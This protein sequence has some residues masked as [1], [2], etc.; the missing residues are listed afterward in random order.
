MI[1]YSIRGGIFPPFIQY[2]I[3]LAIICSAT[4]ASAQPFG[5]SRD[6][7]WQRVGSRELAFSLEAPEGWRFHEVDARGARL[8]PSDDDGPVM[9]VVAW[10]AL[11][12]PATPESAVVEHEGVLSRVVNYRRDAVE[13]I[14]TDDGEAA[15]VVTGRVRWRGGT[16]GV[17]FCAYAAEATHYVLG[18]FAPEATLAQFREDVFDRMMRSFRPHPE[19]DG[20]RDAPARP[21]AVP[22]PVEPTEPG[23][24]VTPDAPDDPDAPEDP[25]L[26]D[27]SEPGIGDAPPT[28]EV[29]RRLEPVG[30]EVD[31]P[32]APWVEHLNPAGFAVSIPIDWEVEVAEG[33]I[34]LTPALEGATAGA[35]LIWP[36]TGPDPGAEAA[37]RMALTPMPE[38]RITRVTSIEDAAAATLIQA[39]AD[40]G[41]RLMA[42]WAHDG[43]HGLLQM[44]AVPAEQWDEALPDLA[45]MIAS[46]RPGEWPVARAAEADFSGE[47]GLLRWRL[48][49]GWQIEGG[50]REDGGE[51]GIDVSA[52]GPGDDALRIRWRQPMQPRFRALTPLLESL[53]WREQ[54][55]YSSPE[56]GE[57]LTIYRRRG[58]EKFV[59][60]MLLARDLDQLR[61]TAI[62]AGPADGR[63][64]D[65][66]PQGGAEGH[67]ITAGGGSPAGPRERLYLAATAPAA[68]PLSTTCWEAAYLLADA[69]E[70]GLAEAVA[71][72]VTMV[73]SARAHD[74]AGTAQAERLEALIDR[75][76]RALGSIP[77]DLQ[78]ESATGLTGVIGGDPQQG[79]A[80]WATPGDAEQHWSEQAGGGDT[81]NLI[82]GPV[83]SRPAA[84]GGGAA[85]TTPGR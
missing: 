80:T 78:P 61:L 31:E 74:T 36:V 48:P 70:G 60:E 4:F 30:P 32:R 77:A 46:F 12:T 39:E 69:P 33:V 66:L 6:A 71:A 9:E 34:A 44:A 63:I 21:P 41:M 16:E 68:P 85:G 28:L 83:R 15:L 49:V 72:L 58:P 84:E 26:F 56:G 53:G 1:K 45:R 7:Q 5:E 13:Q 3:A 76:R 38:L 67:A 52:V 62:D 20:P 24:E 2:F 40:G 19:D 11:R 23:P 14:E 82:E 79:A 37:L 47:T 8:V 55:R 64:A 65:L 42:T 35:A 81:V 57:G 73:G 25:D 59:R 22:E 75:A 17:I 18:T 43:S 54:E 50:A 10:T 27:D 51:L 29:G